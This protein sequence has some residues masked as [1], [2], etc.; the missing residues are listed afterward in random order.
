MKKITEVIRGIQYS[1]QFQYLRTGAT[2]TGWRMGPDLYAKCPQCG[3]YMSLDPVQNESC[4]C[5]N[6][7]KDSDYGRFGARTG[8]ESIKIYQKKK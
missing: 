2:K 4:P 6:L 8:D 1:L 3:Y 7:T 5:G